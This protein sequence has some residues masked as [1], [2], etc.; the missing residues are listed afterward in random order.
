MVK[1]EYKVF[2]INFNN[3]NN[4]YIINNKSNSIYLK[5]QINEA[6]Q[7]I[8]YH[9]ILD[10]GLFSKDDE[11]VV[12]NIS[13]DEI[14]SVMA[15]DSV[16]DKLIDKVKNEK[17]ESLQE[18]LN[19][20]IGVARDEILSNKLDEVLKESA[21]ESDDVIK[22]LTNELLRV[23]NELNSKLLDELKPEFWEAVTDRVCVTN[24]DYIN[25]RICEWINNDVLYSNLTTAKEILN[26]SP[27]KLDYLLMDYWDKR[28][29]DDF[30]DYNNI[31]IGTTNYSNQ[32]TPYFKLGRNRQERL[33]NDEASL[34]KVIIILGSNIDLP[35]VI[36]KRAVA[37]KVMSSPF[38]SSPFVIKDDYVVLESKNDS[39]NIK[40]IEEF[41]KS[42]EISIDVMNSILAHEY[43]A[44][45]NV[46][47]RNRKNN[48]KV[49]ERNKSKRNYKLFEERKFG[50]IALNKIKDHKVNIEVYNNEI[51]REMIRDIDRF[52]IEARGLNPSN[53]SFLIGKESHKSS[54]ENLNIS[55]VLCENEMILE[56]VI[57]ATDI[58]SNIAV[59]VKKGIVHTILKDKRMHIRSKLN[60][61]NS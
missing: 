50:Q 51:S 49:K 25:S 55:D 44:L 2:N 47:K 14:R 10:G 31:P 61:L 23:F 39:T 60:E 54:T 59:K 57:E 11:G 17:N 27:R 58:I 9:N 37:K 18:L 36:F 13:N 12:L 40:K 45:V 24:D 34:W 7:D 6:I 42:D 43:K 53:Y 35:N 19:M 16:S 28:L 5:A 20:D 29:F 48:Y 8:V 15:N 41:F 56:S 33:Q 26:S 4:K 32:I 3:N 1:K 30:L 21:F 38:E 46:G 22:G 52:F